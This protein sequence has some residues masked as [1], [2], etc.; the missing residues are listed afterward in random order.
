MYKRQVYIDCQAAEENGG[1]TIN[2]DVRNG[3]FEDYI[4]EEMF[5][6]FALLLQ[7]I[8]DKNSEVLKEKY[9]VSLMK[10]TLEIRGDVNNTFKNIMPAMLEDCLLYTSRCV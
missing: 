1:A 4:I 5:G 3:V 7:S 8:A 6:S 9:P 10:E 2:W